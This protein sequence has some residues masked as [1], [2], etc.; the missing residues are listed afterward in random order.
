MTIDF[1]AHIVPKADHGCSSAEMARK[2]LELAKKAGVD[3]VVAT[4]HFYPHSMTVEG[5]LERRNRGIS[6]LGGRS[7]GELPGILLGAEVLVCSGM[8][9]MEGLEDL[10]IEGSDSVLLLEL[11]FEDVSKNIWDTIDKMCGRGMRPVLAHLNR[12]PV[13]VIEEGVGTGLPVQI[14]AEAFSSLF[15]RKRW[16]NFSEQ[17]NV[18][19]LGSDIHGC[20]EESYRAFS[21][22]VHVLG[23]LAPPIME[24]TER[25]LKP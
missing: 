14:N 15:A 23:D 8:D 11:P 7:G 24:K 13:K 21:N 20:G 16:K 2:Q 19:A 18:C 9:R 4:P 3:L 6:E 12:Y 25:L 5:F 10:C 22:A 1:H 17:N